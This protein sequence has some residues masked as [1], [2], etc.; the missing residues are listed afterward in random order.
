MNDAGEQVLES[1]RKFREYL[2]AIGQL[3]STAEDML[4]IHGFKAGN[5]YQAV[6][7][8]ET[9]DIRWPAWWLPEDAFR[10]LPYENNVRLLVVISVIM[11][12]INNPESLEQPIVSA[13]WYKYRD[14]SSEYNWNVGF[15]RNILKLKGLQFDGNM[16]DIPPE[17]ITPPTEIEGGAIASC[18]ALAVPLIDI[19]SPEKIE[20]KI[21]TPLI[22]SLKTNSLL[23]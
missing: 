7:K 1:T 3:L 17:K 10:F 14:E 2:K 18:K 6:S 13:A 11:D 19:V 12:D 15:S 23:S 8:I 4:A 22:E 20:E 5:Y 21:I 16:N 9:A